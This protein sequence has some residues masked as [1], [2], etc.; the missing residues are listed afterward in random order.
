MLK[1]IFISKLGCNKNCINRDC[2][3]FGFCIQG[4]VDGYWGRNCD[5]VCPVTCIELSCNR[6]TGHCVTCISGYW[7]YTCTLLCS[8]FCYGGV[9]DKTNGKCTLGCTPGR[10]GEICD[11]ICDWD[12]SQWM[13]TELVRGLLQ[14]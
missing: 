9:C 14:Q 2:D 10:N 4:C 7:G 11:R 5:S 8:S 1:Y 12:L 6:I 3:A 13:Q